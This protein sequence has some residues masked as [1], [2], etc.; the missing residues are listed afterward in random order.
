M[1]LIQ[2]DLEQLNL[3]LKI[4]IGWLVCLL[5]L[6]FFVYFGALIRRS[7]RAWIKRQNAERD[8][9]NSL[10]RHDYAENDQAHIADNEQC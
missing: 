6:R 2:I 4:V 8:Y 5:L 10:F 1:I 9:W 3:I 7:F